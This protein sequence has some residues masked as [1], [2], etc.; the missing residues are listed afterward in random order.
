M[1]PV[2]CGGAVVFVNPFIFCDHK[3]GK[4][5]EG[6]IDLEQ[7]RGVAKKSRQA[8]CDNYAQCIKRMADP[9]PLWKAPLN[10]KYPLIENND[11]HL[12]DKGD[13]P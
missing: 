13:C 4:D 6:D 5:G 7:G 8:Q 12:E 1:N 2:F 11:R 9:F 10:V 3:A